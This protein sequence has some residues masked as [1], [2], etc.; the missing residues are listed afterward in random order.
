MREDESEAILAIPPIVRIVI[1]R[2]Q[3]HTVVVTIRIEQFRIAV[4]IVRNASYATVLRILSGL[5]LIRYLKY[6]S[7]SHQV[8]SIF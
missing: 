7:I 8:S 1:G 3:P 5:N 4:R 6:H 2:V